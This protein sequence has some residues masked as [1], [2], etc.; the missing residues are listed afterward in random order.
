MPEPLTNYHPPESGDELLGQR[1]VRPDLARDHLLRVAITL[2]SMFRRFA[3]AH[4]QQ[5]EEYDADQRQRRNQGRTSSED[6][7]ERGRAWC[8][9]PRQ[10]PAAHRYG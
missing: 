3:L 5:F 4:P 9:R 8:G 7:G 6:H 10:R 2:T 1:A